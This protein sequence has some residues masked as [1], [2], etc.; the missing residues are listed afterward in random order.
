MYVLDYLYRY[1]NIDF[2]EVPFNEVDALVLAMVSYFPFDELKDQKEIYPSDELLK[3]I[4]KRILK[5][6]LKY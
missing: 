2:R 5:W 4:L 1:Q 3:R 6:I